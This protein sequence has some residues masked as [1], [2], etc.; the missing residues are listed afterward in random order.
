[1]KIIRQ[2]DLSRLDKTRR[3]QCHD[4]G[5]IWDVNQTEYRYESDGRNGDTWICECPTCGRKSYDSQL[6]IY[7]KQ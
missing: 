4:C 6:L 5:C 1:M 2:G 7:V 3:F